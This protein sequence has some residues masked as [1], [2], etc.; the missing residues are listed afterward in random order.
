[1]LDERI[2]LLSPV[3]NYF[4]FA[5]NPASTRNLAN[6]R[7]RFSMS[8]SAILHQ[9]SSRSAFRFVDNTPG[10]RTL[11]LRMAKHDTWEAFAGS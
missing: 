8:D 5:R 3:E 10:I 7:P 4:L 9:L 1:M 6:T 2:G 11:T